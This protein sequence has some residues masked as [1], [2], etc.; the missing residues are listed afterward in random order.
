MKIELEVPF[1]G[2]YGN[3]VC[4]ARNS[5]ALSHV[6]QSCNTDLEQYQNGTPLYHKNRADK[7]VEGANA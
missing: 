2:L 4:T 1:L 6:Q 7:V 3:Q 5:T